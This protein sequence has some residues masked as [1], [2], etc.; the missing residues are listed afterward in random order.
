MQ[1]LDSSG[2]I[3]ARLLNRNILIE[4]EY[5]PRERGY[6]TSVHHARH[7]HT[8]WLVVETDTPRNGRSFTELIWPPIDGIETFT[9]HLLD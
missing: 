2:P 3:D 8:S 1:K 5:G 4:W 9:I 6:V 7:I